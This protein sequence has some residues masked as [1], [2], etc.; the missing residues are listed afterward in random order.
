M[1]LTLKLIFGRNTQ[2]GNK[3][4]SLNALTMFQIQTIRHVI[5]T[6][7]TAQHGLNW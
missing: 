2:D 6:V 7:T 1:D 5:K 3:G 4:R